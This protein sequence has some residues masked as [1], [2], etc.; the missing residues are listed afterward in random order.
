[1]NQQILEDLLLKQLNQDFLAKL[2][3]ENP[4]EE[5]VSEYKAELLELAEAKFQNL[6]IELLSDEEAEQIANSSDESILNTILTNKK[7][8]FEEIA[9]AA[10]N[11]SLRDIESEMAY[12]NGLID[13]SEV[14]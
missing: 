14:E 2:G 11:E 1:M 13:G 10:V 7:L 4:T 5:E 3:I 9:A 12:I 6:L 8:N